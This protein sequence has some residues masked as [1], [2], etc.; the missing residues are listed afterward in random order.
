MDNLAITG[1]HHGKVAQCREASA[2]HLSRQ[3]TI[4]KVTAAKSVVYMTST[5]GAGLATYHHVGSL[6]CLVCASEQMREISWLDQSSDTFF[7][8]SWSPQ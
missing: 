8:S 7:A 5:K 3:V 2:S 4:L 6:T 1:E